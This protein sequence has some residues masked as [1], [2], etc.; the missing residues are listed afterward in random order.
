MDLKPIGWFHDIDPFWE[1]V[2]NFLRSQTSFEL[3]FL[4]FLANKYEA[5]LKVQILSNWSYRYM[6]RNWHTK[7]KKLVKFMVNY[8]H[9]LYPLELSQ[10][11]KLTLSN[12]RGS[13]GPQIKKGRVSLCHETML[14]CAQLLTLEKSIQ[15][16]ISF[17]RYE[18]LIM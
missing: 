8:F 7:V 15:Y 12:F 17:I 11:S 6:E 3:N 10:L 18:F 9:N 13:C 16:A 1:A 14:S 5:T 2:T 4:Y